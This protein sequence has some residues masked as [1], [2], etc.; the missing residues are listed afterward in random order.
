MKCPTFRRQHALIKDQKAFCELR[1]KHGE[2]RE[3]I[4]LAAVA[5][6]GQFKWWFFPLPLIQFSESMCQIEAQNI[7]NTMV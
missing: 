2:L 4:G 5:K 3:N 1:V 6:N 7:L